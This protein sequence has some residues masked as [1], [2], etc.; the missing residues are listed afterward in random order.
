LQLLHFIC[1]NFGLYL[2]ILNDHFTPYSVCPLTLIW[3]HLIP[4]DAWIQSDVQIWSDTSGSLTINSFLTPFFDYLS[5]SLF[6]CCIN[7][8]WL[9]PL[10]PELNTPDPKLS[11]WRFQL[12]PPIHTLLSLDLSNQMDMLHDSALLLL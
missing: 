4:S 1:L 11:W 2:Q 5:F 7:N 10:C 6:P 8:I 9:S 3:S 12:L